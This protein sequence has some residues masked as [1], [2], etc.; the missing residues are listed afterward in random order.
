MRRGPFT[1]LELVV[2]IAI[3]AITTTLAVSAFRGES[4]A[5][6]LNNSALGF[7]SWC[8]RVRYVAMENGAD[9]VIAFK[10]D[11]RLFTAMDPGLDPDAVQPGDEKP[12]LE[13]KLPDEF[14]LDSETLNAEAAED[15]A[16]EVFRFFSDGSANASREFILKYRKLQRRFRVSPLTGMLLQSE[17]A[18]L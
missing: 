14:E 10:P 13:W 11:E 17:E 16:I 1:L 15:G 4:P 6:K 12:A 18:V 9:R 7:E 8:A 3:I 2:V 5:Q